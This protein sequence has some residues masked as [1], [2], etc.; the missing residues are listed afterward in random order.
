M[1]PKGIKVYL[2]IHPKFDIL[3]P[4]DIVCEKCDM[5]LSKNI[6]HEHPNNPDG[7]SCLFCELNITGDEYNK[8]TEVARNLAI[9]YFY[10]TRHRM[11][12][13]KDPVTLKDIDPNQ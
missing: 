5:L 8:S 2:T 7:W 11:P 10:K 6:V 3:D 13:I 12:G 4:E 9:G 1:I